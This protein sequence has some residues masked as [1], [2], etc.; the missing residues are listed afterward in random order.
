MHDLLA[1][2]WDF[3]LA[4]TVSGSKALQYSHSPGTDAKAQAHKLGQSWEGARGEKQHWRSGAEAQPEPRPAPAQHGFPVLTLAEDEQQVLSDSITADDCVGKTVTTSQGASLERWGGNCSRLLGTGVGH[5]S[6]WWPVGGF[7]TA[8]NPPPHLRNGLKERQAEPL[9][10]GEGSD[11]ARHL[12]G[13]HRGNVGVQVG[14]YLLEDLGLVEIQFSLK[15]QRESGSHLQGAGTGAVPGQ[16][17]AA[18]G[19]ARSCSLGAEEA[20]TAV[21]PPPVGLAPSFLVRPSLCRIL[22]HPPALSHGA[23]SQL[24]PPP[25]AGSK[26]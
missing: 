25:S 16:A 8:P 23:N 24:Q 11:A 9:E 4:S 17:V 14:G 12:D 7:L 26:F 19:K 15:E 13:R 2:P 18:Q 5:Q 20:R 22:R 6:Y 21:L 10:E 3:I 1:L